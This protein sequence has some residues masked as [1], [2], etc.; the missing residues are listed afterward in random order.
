MT[1]LMVPGLVAAA[2]I[3]LTYLFCVR[4]MR[5]DRQSGLVGMGHGRSCCGDLD[6]QD[7]PTEI[8]RLHAEIAELRGQQRSGPP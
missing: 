3:T 4:P 1:D 7:R 2:A 8:D 5:R 6:S